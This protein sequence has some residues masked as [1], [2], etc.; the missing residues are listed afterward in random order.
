MNNYPMWLNWMFMIAG[1]FLI[2][3]GSGIIVNGWINT[4]P[5]VQDLT[6]PT[7]YTYAA[8][9]GEAVAS[10]GWALSCATDINNLKNRVEQLEKGTGEKGKP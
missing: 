5:T 10:A 7:Q 2:V 4:Q 1:A 8:R 9:E 6:S 3:I